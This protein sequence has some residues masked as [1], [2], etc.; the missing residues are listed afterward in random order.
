MLNS[1]SEAQPIRR[2]MTPEERRRQLLGIG[3]RQLVDRPIQELSLDAVAAEA[4]ISRG[5]LFHYFPTKQAFHDAVVG[6][7]TRRTL[8]NTA[9]DPD[10]TGRE[11]L[12]QFVERFLAQVDRRR[13]FYLALVFG[14]GALALGGD[15]VEDLRSA[16]AERVVDRLG[17]P[18]TATTTVHA[19]TAYVEDRALQWSASA[20]A[21][22]ATTLAEETAHARAALDALLACTGESDPGV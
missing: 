17:L 8:R 11:A 3:L 19:W 15:R 21:D 10:A 9:P 1:V 18:A 5:L 14:N 22:R 12:D 13:D 4:G 16:F 7:A 2:R 20:P 6:A